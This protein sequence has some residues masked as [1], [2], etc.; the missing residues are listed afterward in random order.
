M[1]GVRDSTS[2]APCYAR[3]QRRPELKAKLAVI[4]REVRK[5]DGERIQLEQQL[6]D[7]S[8]Q[9]STEKSEELKRLREAHLLAYLSSIPVNRLSGISGIGP[10][11]IG[12]LQAAGIRNAADL[13]RRGP[14]VQG[15]GT[16][17]RGQ[18]CGLLAQWE[19]DAARTMP[20]SLPVDVERPVTAKHQAQRNSV[21]DR[22]R[23]VGAM[24]SGPRTEASQ[25]ESELKQLH[26]P[27]FGQFLRNTM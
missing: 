12:N 4:E 20:N 10:V 24:L 14:H 18:I 17:R 8:Q 5:R 19:R 2:P 3:V 23:A 26:V 7:L 27:T 9:E 13:K 22:R 16:K 1:P 25:A 11:I 6:R 21:T 15:V